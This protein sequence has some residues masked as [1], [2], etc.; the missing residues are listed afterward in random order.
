MEKKEVRQCGLC[1]EFPCD[2]FMDSYDPSKGL[3]SSVARAGIWLI[4]LSMVM[5]KRFNLPER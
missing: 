5:R 4:E 1:E 3:V 2:L